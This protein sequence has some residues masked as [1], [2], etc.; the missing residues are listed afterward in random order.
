MY[1]NSRHSAASPD[2]KSRRRALWLAS[3]SRRKVKPTY[4]SRPLLTANKVTE[5][6]L[7]KHACFSSRNLQNVSFSANCMS[8]DPP[9]RERIA[10]G[11]IRRCVGGQ[12]DLTHCA[13]ANKSL[14]HSRERI[15]CARTPRSPRHEPF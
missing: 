7:A 13:A 8:R 2:A 9:P 12:E 11:G 5:R 4:R 1:I 10:D 15:S 14:A 3:V 6:T